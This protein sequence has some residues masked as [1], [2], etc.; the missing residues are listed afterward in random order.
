MVGAEEAAGL[1]QM[2]VTHHFLYNAFY[3]DDFFFLIILQFPSLTLNNFDYLVNK[4][5]GKP[6]KY[7]L[8]LI[9]GLSIIQYGSFT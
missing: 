2:S 4:T 9:G 6:S 3:V 1:F 8:W 5:K 7:W